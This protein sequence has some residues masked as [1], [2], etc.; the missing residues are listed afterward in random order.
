MTDKSFEQVKIDRV[1]AFRR[2][3]QAQRLPREEI[4]S[5]SVSLEARL[6]RLRMEMAAEQKDWENSSW[7]G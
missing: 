1:L 5:L 4:D 6:D 3:C 7:L 2:E